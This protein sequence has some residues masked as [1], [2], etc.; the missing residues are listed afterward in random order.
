MI[1]LL[2]FVGL[3]NAAVWFGSAVFFSFDASPAAA[4]SDMQELLSWKN[5]P[6]FSVAIE[7]LLAARFFHLYVACS[8]VALL[9]LLA[10]WLYLGKYPQRLWLGLLLGLCLGG[11][12]Q[13]YAIQPRLSA[14]HQLQFTRPDLRETAA[15]VYRAW[16]AVSTGLDVVLIAGLVVYV[17][18]VAYPPD[19]TRFV[20]AAKFRS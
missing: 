16:H 15:R 13:V 7:Q 11:L 9:H 5:Y 19:P 14:S 6:Y 4:S 3:I 17:W 1:G 10:E 12:V 8:I 20:N 18:R 2:R